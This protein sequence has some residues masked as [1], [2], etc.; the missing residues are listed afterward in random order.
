LQTTIKVRRFDFTVQFVWKPTSPSERKQK[1]AEAGEQ[2]GA[3][4]EPAPGA[5]PAPGAGGQPAPGA[6]QPG[7][8]APK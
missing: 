8:A 2:P 6:Q 1:K 5:Q 4:G 7:E 3:P